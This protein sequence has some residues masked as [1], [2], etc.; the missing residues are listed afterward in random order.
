MGVPHLTDTNFT[1][2]A[3]KEFDFVTPENEMK[4][5]TAEP[6]QG[7]FNFTPGDQ[8]VTFAM[9]N[10]M[11]VKGHTLVWHNQ[12]P[13]WVTNLTGATAVTTAMTN[14][15][16]GMMTHFKGKVI[17]WD[18]VN[19]AWSTPNMTGVGPATIW[20]DVFGTNLGAGYI[21]TAFQLA[22]KTDPNVLLFY[23]DFAIEGMNDKSNAVYNM[24]SSM[25]HRGVPIDGVG[26]Q[27]HYGTFTNAPT[28]ADFTQNLK[29]FTDLGLKVVLSE[30]DVNC[31]E[32]I[33]LSQ[34]PTL[35]HDI[36]AA[37][38]ANPGC[39]ALTIWGISDKDSWL[40]TYNLNGCSNGVM[41][42]P[43]LFDA[44]FAKK[45]AY[46]STLNALMGR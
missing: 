43:L 3:S 30:M 45:P 36:V 15:I 21:D 19:E 42:T 39:Y 5:D 13:A 1:G 11:K 2:T 34:E 24:V 37:C 40:N 35:Y 26:M 46:A 44:N 4:W 27:M 22:R 8:V 38:V 7:T 23:N 25:I 33:P 12:L 41:P 17:A 18:V 9:Q 29:R 32:N 20:N 14:H 16:T 28:A 10:N 6:T 31:C